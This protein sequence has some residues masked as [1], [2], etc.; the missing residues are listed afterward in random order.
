[1][2]IYR[3]LR[4]HVV[5]QSESPLTLLINAEGL[6]TTSAW[7]NARLDVSGDPN[8]FDAIV[9]LSFEADRPG[10]IVPQ[11][12]TPISATLIMTPNHG[13]DAVVI[14]SR[15]NS[16]TVHASEFIVPF[17]PGGQVTTFAIGEE[18]PPT[19][20]P[21]FEEA[22]T[23]LRFG[24]E[25]PTFAQLGSEGPTFAQPGAEGPT[26]YRWGE[27]EPSLLFG[28]DPTTRAHGEEPFTDPRVDDPIGPIFTT[29]VLGE[30]N[31]AGG[32]FGPG[33]GPFGG[34]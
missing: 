17:V 30:E 29:Q 32:G 15:T 31:P 10:G 19:T 7:S 2:K 3:V 28:E 21:R 14:N 13:A 8:P 16:L 5:R 22:P 11:L 9:E 33:G 1:M 12:L 34:F 20:G 26:T 25:G 4:V 6:T 18:V 27:E 24:E 23:T